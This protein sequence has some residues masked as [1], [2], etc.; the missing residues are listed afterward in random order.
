MYHVPLAVQFIYRWRDEEG[1]DGAS[2]YA[3]YLVLCDEPEED[4]RT[5]VGWFAEVC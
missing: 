5:I 1:E 2:L 3:D 4:L